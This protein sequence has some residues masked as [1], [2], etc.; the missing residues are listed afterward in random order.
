MPRFVVTTEANLNAVHR[1][2]LKLHAGV[3]HRDHDATYASSSQGDGCFESAFF[4]GCRCP[5]IS[6]CVCQC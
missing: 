4:W 3:K 2:A 1:A 6:F 5:W